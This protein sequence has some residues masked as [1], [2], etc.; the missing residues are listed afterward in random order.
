MEKFK[1]ELFKKIRIELDGYFHKYGLQVIQEQIRVPWDFPLCNG[2]ADTK[3]PL[4]RQQMMYFNVYIGGRYFHICFIL[5]VSCDLKHTNRS[6]HREVF[7]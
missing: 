2:H 5:I 1:K 7:S 6:S 3:N 4:L